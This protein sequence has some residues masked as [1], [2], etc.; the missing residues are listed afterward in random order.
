[1]I[2]PRVKFL[3][4]GRCL[5]AIQ[6]ITCPDR[7]V[8]KESRVYLQTCSLGQENFLHTGVGK[9]P[10]CYQAFTLR[11]LAAHSR[12]GTTCTQPLWFGPSNHFWGLWPA[13]SAL[14]R[15]K[16]E[17]GSAGHERRRACPSILSCHFPRVVPRSQSVSS[18]VSELAWLYAHLD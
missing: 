2:F 18:Y 17:E 3:F 5:S 11:P 7:D 6:R 14:N 8:C 10:S 12:Q 13:V 9:Q 1:M 15:R 4:E 16:A